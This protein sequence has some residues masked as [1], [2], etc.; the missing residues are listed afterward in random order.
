[1]AFI[2]TKEKQKFDREWAKLRNE[3]QAAGMSA[4]DIDA[5]YAYDW[6]CF[7]S[8]RKFINHTQNL[9]SD[10]I[11]DEDGKDRKDRSSLILKFTSLS[12]NFDE[13]EIGGRYG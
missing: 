2:Y 1:M 8:R 6:R 3:Y 7:C 11:E 9:P 12:V 5:L 10:T 4:Q 13:S